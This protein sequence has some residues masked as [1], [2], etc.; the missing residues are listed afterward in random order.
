MYRSALFATVCL[1]IGGFALPV[2]ATSETDVRVL[3]DV[4]GSM[5]KNDP[6]NLRIP[7]M[8]LMTELLPEG[9]RA[10]VWLFGES[11]QVLLPPAEVDQSW[12]KRARAQI[13]KIH[14]RGLFTHIEQA[15]ESA[16]ADWA[17]ASSNGARHIVLLTDGMVD[18]SKAASES[19]ASRQRIITGQLQRLQSYGAHVHAIALS[20]NVD[21]ELLGALTETTGGLL[22]TARDAGRLERIFL[23]MLEQ[24]AAPI[25]VPI[26]GRMFDID[27]SVSEFTLLLFRADDSPSV[28][29]SPSGA[30]FNEKT[31]QA[32]VAWRR[33]P[34]YDLITIQTPET[35]SWRFEGNEDPDNRAVIITDLAMATTAITGSVMNS[36]SVQYE[37]WLTSARE[38]ITNPD[39]LK[40]V[41]ATQVVRVQG[42][43][44][45]NE[46]L[47][48]ES[49]EHVF[50]GHFDPSTL[51]PGE[52][53]L[54]IGFD[55]G[56]FKRELNRIIRVGDDPVSIDY[57]INKA[58]DGVKITAV[59]DQTRIK[60]HSLAGYVSVL[61]P[62][63]SE[64][65]YPFKA[66]P[67][68][69]ATAEMEAMAAGNHALRAH[70]Y[71]TTTHGRGVQ[72]E[73]APRDIT[74]DPALVA[75]EEP[76]EEP[77]RDS[78]SAL[79]TLAWVG[80]ANLLLGLGFAVLWWTLGRSAR[81]AATGEAA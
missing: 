34:G 11:S 43:D 70:T 67:D 15:L 19:A 75:N 12:R 74:L 6:Q 7:A 56:T 46:P 1:V 26:E 36:E 29:H 30:V 49:G 39:L 2:L 58:R 3:I 77:A 73:P 62:D 71:M 13:D 25:T 78:F 55:G 81:A 16:S 28:L 24:T 42:R 59:A 14:S 47:G 61:N 35:G 37:A 31:Q 8:R 76:K 4:S 51:E 27:Q 57:A 33:E 21:H 40:V 9:S 66:Q 10:G 23:H 5:K 53:R 45:S 54:T 60:L 63:G 68:G 18:V 80:G 72:I 65:A 64:R 17:G 69:S 22:E 48:N 50:R 79:L 32:G 38:P 44:V 20:D 52:Y 41:S